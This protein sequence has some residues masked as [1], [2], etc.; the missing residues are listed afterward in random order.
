MLR[1]VGRGAS[2]ILGCGLLALAAGSCGDSTAGDGTS[3]ADASAG[4]EATASD[5]PP[6]GTA[7]IGADTTVTADTADTVA[8]ADAT[9]ATETMGIDCDPIG[10]WPDTVDASYLVS[11]TLAGEPQHSGGAPALSADGRFAVYH[12]ANDPFV[13]PAE[14]LFD[15]FVYD[16]ACDTTIAVPFEHPDEP[17]TEAVFPT[18]SDDGSTVAF[19]S[20][21]ANLDLQIWVYDVSSDA[22]E[23]ASLDEAGMPVLGTHDGPVLSADGRFVAFHSREPLVA[24][25]DNGESDVYVRDRQAGTIER[26]SLTDVGAQADGV[27][28]WPAISADGRFVA[29]ESWS[30]LA[31]ETGPPPQVYV[32]DRQRG[33]TELVSV[34]RGTPSNGVAQ[35]A[36]ISGDGRFV[37]WHGNASNLVADDA[38]GLDDVFVRDRQ[39][40]TL[41]RVSLLRPPKAGGTYDAYVAA[42]P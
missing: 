36:S 11:R 12:S 27:S 28:E 30:E 9:D 35:R 3:S 39:S 25:D 42:I 38:N 24:D 8:T 33:T 32:R 20:R 40:G 19:V 41:E 34:G 22:L 37:A 6:T 10:P 17:V 5:G 15:V 21:D 23:L 2:R 13:Q 7:T 1:S 26:V 4:T 29:F 16:A 31:G 18:I 14:L